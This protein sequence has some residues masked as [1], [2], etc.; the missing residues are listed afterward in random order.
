MNNSISDLFKAPTIKVS[1]APAAPAP[2]VVVPAAPIVPA[3]AT[4]DEPLAA[5]WY[6]IAIVVAAAGWWPIAQWV[7]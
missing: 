6:I 1:T 4:A 2:V 7:A 5:T 3:V